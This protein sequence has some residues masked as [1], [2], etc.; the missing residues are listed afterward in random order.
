[1]TMQSRCESFAVASQLP[2]K[3]EIEIVNTYEIENGRGNGREEGV[4]EDGV[5]AT[6]RR[7]HLCGIGGASFDAYDVVMRCVKREKICEIYIY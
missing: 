2:C 4:L 1:M 7:V 5:R 3:S 6:A